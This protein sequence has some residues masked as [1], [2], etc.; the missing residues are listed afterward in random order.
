MHIV[1]GSFTSEHSIVLNGLRMY[2]LHL[3]GFV[4]Y[5]VPVFGIQVTADGPMARSVVNT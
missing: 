4:G 2:A 1:P 3:K 5:Y